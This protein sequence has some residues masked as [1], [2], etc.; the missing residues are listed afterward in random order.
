[1]LVQVEDAAV[2]PLVVRKVGRT[3]EQTLDVTFYDPTGESSDAR[4]RLASEK[5]TVTIYRLV[6]E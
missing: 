2:V 3:H 5:E 1:M 4:Y 6:A